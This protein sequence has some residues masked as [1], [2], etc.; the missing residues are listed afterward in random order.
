MIT[1]FVYQPAAVVPSLNALGTKPRMKE[2]KEEFVDDVVLVVVL[3]PFLAIERG[4][5]P[6]GVL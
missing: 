1:F 6:A 3:L 4:D 5:G 2:T